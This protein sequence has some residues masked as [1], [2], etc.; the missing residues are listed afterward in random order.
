ML[1]NFAVNFK[2][3]ELPA[4]NPLPDYN[5]KYQIDYWAESAAKA[6]AEASILPVDGV[7]RPNENATRGEAADMFMR[8]LEFA[9][10]R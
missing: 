7:L 5:D 2:G 10:E 4:D 9:G 8:F 1:Y 6:L 3:F